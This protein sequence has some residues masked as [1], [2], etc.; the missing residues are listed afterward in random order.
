MF[1]SNPNSSSDEFKEGKEELKL[2]ESDP[3]LKKATFA[4]G[5]FWCM[6]GPLESVKGVEGVVLGYTG[7]GRETALVFYDP[8][9][10]KY[11]DLV[12]MYWKF[13]DPTD[14]DGQFAD[15]GSR[16]HLGIFYHTQ[17]QQEIAAQY[18]REMEESGKY[19]KPITVELL[20]EEDFKLA[21]DYH[22]NYYKKQSKNYK[23]YYRGSG[24]Q[25]FVE[26]N[27]FE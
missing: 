3:K 2:F 24:R 9:I 1:K 22:Q 7:G 11:K 5:C 16:Y 13:I 14:P 10:T 23:E 20:P 19:D 17:E 6:E 21:E 4:G 8:N 27:S 18:I 15:R 12:E 26:S 25:A